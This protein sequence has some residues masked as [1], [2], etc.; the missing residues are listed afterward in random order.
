MNLGKRYKQLFEGKTRSN[1]NK[2]LTENEY[3]APTGDKRTS[4]QYNPKWEKGVWAF[5]ASKSS[6]G[7]GGAYW[8]E[9]IAKYFDAVGI[10]YNVWPDPDNK[11]N[12]N[13][14]VKGGSQIYKSTSK[15]LGMFFEN[16]TLYDLMK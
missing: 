11:D 16:P 13:L 15:I 5:A 7:A 2:L 9:Y 8:N 14:Q 12:I 1:D 6:P 10:E 3:D 4:S